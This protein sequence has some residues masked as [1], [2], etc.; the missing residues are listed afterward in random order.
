MRS[1]ELSVAHEERV[2]ELCVE[3]LVVRDSLDQFDEGGLAYWMAVAW[4]GRLVW[5]DGVGSVGQI[6]DVVGGGQGQ[7]ELR[8]LFL[9]HLLQEP[10]DAELVL[11][12]ADLRHPLVFFMDGVTYNY[13]ELLLLA[14]A[15]AVVQA[16]AR[17]GASQRC[18]FELFWVQILIKMEVLSKKISKC[19]YE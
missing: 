2:S 4:I 17:R 10:V 12:V 1:T 16:T 15:S 18:I 3:M 5:D 14:A 19:K 11:W 9:G 6:E 8:I 13:D 7:A